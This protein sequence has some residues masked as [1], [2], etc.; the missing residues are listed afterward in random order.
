MIRESIRN[1]GNLGALKGIKMALYF[2][3]III[4]GFELVT[5]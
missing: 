2:L 5:I 4:R 3:L 1:W